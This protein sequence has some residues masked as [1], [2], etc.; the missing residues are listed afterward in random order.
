[1]NYADSMRYIFTGTYRGLHDT[2]TPMRV[3]MI[4]LCIISVGSSYVLG[5]ILNEGAIGIRIGLACGIVCSTVYLA[6]SFFMGK[7]H[8]RLKS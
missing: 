4:G 6:Y 5:H 2:K 1:M 3:G 8:Q 7:L